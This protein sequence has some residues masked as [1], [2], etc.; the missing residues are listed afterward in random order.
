MI[1][2]LSNTK[3]AFYWVSVF[4][5]NG[6]PCTVFIAWMSHSKENAKLHWWTSGKKEHKAMPQCWKVDEGVHNSTLHQK[7]RRNLWDFD[8]HRHPMTNWI[9]LNYFILLK[10]PKKLRSLAALPSLKHND[11]WETFFFPFEIQCYFQGRFITRFMENMAAVELDHLVHGESWKAGVQGWWY[12]AI[13]IY[14][15]IYTINICIYL[16]IKYHIHTMNPN[17]T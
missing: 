4:F 1:I 13:Q 9:G 14:I 15:Y 5:V 6:L 12:D 2:I 16:F 10:S 3:H 8:L 17:M 11:T 7:S